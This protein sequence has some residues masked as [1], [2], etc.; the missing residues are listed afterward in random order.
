MSTGVSARFRMS[1]AT[2][3]QADRTVSAATTIAAASRPGG[4]AA[5]TIISSLR[6]SVIQDLLSTS[7]VMIRRSNR[8]DG[9]VLGKSLFDQ[10]HRRVVRV[11]RNRE[12][13][14][15]AHLQHRLVLAQ[16]LADQLADAALAGDIYE[17][18]HQQVA[19]T[20]ALPVAAH[21]DRIFGPQFVGIGR[22]SC[23]P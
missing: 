15:P 6:A 12:A 13:E 9:T 17:A 8:R 5:P 4:V 20:A 18:R 11:E 22:K 1:T 3:P 21:G 19:E 10:H 14:L 23:D 16:D 2:S 7:A